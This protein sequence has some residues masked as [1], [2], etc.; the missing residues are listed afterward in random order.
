MKKKLEHNNNSYNIPNIS[1]TKRGR[2]ELK[3]FSSNTRKFELC[4]RI[5]LIKSL[6]IFV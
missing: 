6:Y 5:V 4:S 2:C 1:P 3:I